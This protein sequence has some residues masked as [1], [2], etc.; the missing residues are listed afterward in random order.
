M[1]E[2]LYLQRTLKIETRETFE[3]IRSKMYLENIISIYNHKYV[4]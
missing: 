1:I 3:T 4:L 2:S